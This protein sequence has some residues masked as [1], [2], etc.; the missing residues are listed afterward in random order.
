MSLKIVPIHQDEAFAFV[1]QNHRHHK[2]PRGAKFCLAVADGD[3]IVG[4]ATVGRPVARALQDGWTLEVNRL[5]TDGTKNACSMLYSAC[6]RVAREMGYHKLITYILD[7][8]TGSSLKAANWRFVGARGGG[9]WNM[10]SRPR[11]DKHP[12]Q[13]KLM[14]EITI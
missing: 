7:T 10:P 12:T 6:W 3:R 2:A 13:Q 1:T 14:F 5:C 9:T 4:V 8:E 11:V